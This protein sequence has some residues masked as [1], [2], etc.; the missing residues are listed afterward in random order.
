MDLR[1][2]KCTNYK[3]ENA[4]L[5]HCKVCQYVLAKRAGPLSP[6]LSPSL[7]H[8]HTRTHTQDNHDGIKPL[9]RSDF[10]YI[11]GRQESQNH[12]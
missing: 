4:N 2:K 9:S 6:S 3:N 5:I 7:S 11:Q 12:R 10:N 1:L 8:T